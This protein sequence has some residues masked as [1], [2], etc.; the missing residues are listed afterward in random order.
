M[1]TGEK[2]RILD[3]EALGKYLSE[4]DSKMK[5][6]GLTARIESV[7]TE[8]ENKLYTL[9]IDQGRHVWG[10]VL[11]CSSRKND[12]TDH[13]QRWDLL[14]LQT[15]EEV[16]KVYT[17]GAEKYG[18]NTWQN[19]P[20]GYQRYKAALFRHLLEFEKGNEIDAETGCHHLAQVCW[21]ALAMLH[22][23]LNE[24]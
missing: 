3:R 1:E 21:N 6:A 16:V 8:G 15:L 20:D 12:F 18:A 24:K 17:A 23:T 11:F 5:Y 7:E 4:D 9:N 19:L 22:I 2:V 10:E 14:P 13:K